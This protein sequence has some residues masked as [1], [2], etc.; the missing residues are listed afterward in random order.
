MCVHM[1]MCMHV[2]AHVCVCVYV[3]SKFYTSSSAASHHVC[4]MCAWTCLST[5][6]SIHT[7]MLHC[8]GGGGRGQ[9]HFYL[10]WNRMSLLCMAVV[11]RLAGPCDHRDSPVHLSSYY[12]STEIP[13]SHCHAW[14]SMGS[15]NS[16]SRHRA[17]KR[18]LCLVS[19]AFSTTG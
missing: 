8:M 17:S 12:R 16:N 19:H 9:L 6:V 14:L 7:C 13:H 5:C 1:C 3:T 11:R 2:C 18:A 4:N 10:V 15:A